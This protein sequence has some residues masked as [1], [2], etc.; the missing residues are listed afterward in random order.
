LIFISSD[1]ITEDA[2]MEIALEAGADDVTEEDGYWQITCPPADF[3][4]LKE[5][6]VAA[7][8]TLENAELTW[9]PQTM[10]QCDEKT[11]RQILRLIDVFDDHDD[12]QAV[13]HNAAI[14]EAS[15]EG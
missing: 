3:I 6:L 4:I 15:L 8:L 14:P 13:H 7:E 2:L 5:A 1:A 12:V 10:I 9:T 11:G